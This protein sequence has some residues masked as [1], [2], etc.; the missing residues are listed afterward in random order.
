MDLSQLPKMSDTPKPPTMPPASTPTPDV[1]RDPPGGFGPVAVWMS[2]GI[3]LIFLMLGSNVLHWAAARTAGRAFPEGVT[4]TAGDRAGQPVG[5]YELQGG[6]GWTETGFFVM[7]VALL[8]DALLL[9]FV[10]GSRR[11][12][13]ALIAAALATTGLALAFN[14]FAAADVFGWGMMPINSMIAVVVGGIMLFEQI[15]LWRATRG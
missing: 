12:R 5:Y 11:P 15:G 3:G 10:Y 2:L 14:L 1:H 9:F 13:P 7:G 8:I 4:W 6:T